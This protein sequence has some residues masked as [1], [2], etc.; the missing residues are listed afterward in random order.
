MGFKSSWFK[1]LGLKIP[2]SKYHLSRGAARGGAEGA[3]AP[4]EFG[5]SVNPIQIRGG[6]FC[7]SH[8]CQPPWIQ[9]A[10]YTSAF[11]KVKIHFNPGLFNHEL[12]NPMVQKFTVEKSGVEKFGV[13]RSG[14]ECWG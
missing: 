14:V 9:K 10:I 3:G 2:G 8:Y 7:P 1:S 13:E 6:R 4:P 12:F 11:Y 5:R